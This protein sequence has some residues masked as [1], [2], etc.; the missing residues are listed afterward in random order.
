MRALLVFWMCLAFTFQGL[1]GTRIFEPTCPMQPDMASVMTMADA[2]GDCCND[3]ETAA[4]TGQLCKIGQV[5]PSPFAT[6]ITG[7][8]LA[9]SATA[10]S[11]PDAT[12]LAFALS[13]DPS[14]V[15]RPPTFH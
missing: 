8:S 10:A 2:R 12:A 11:A 15:W 3:A 9:S 5:C 7:L 1:A 14:G 4:S 13:T 6:G